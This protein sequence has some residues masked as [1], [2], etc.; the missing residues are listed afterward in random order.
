[1]KDVY[2]SFVSQ[3]MLSQVIIRS[4]CELHGGD[5]RVWTGLGGFTGNL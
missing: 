4:I 5:L 3:S 2:A 1:M